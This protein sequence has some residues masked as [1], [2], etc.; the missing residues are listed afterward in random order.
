MTSRDAPLSVFMHTNRA[1]RN[2]TREF[3]LSRGWW[4]DTHDLRPLHRRYERREF[5]YHMKFALHQGFKYQWLFATTR[6]EAEP[7]LLADTD[8]VIQCTAQEMRERFA[9]AAASKHKRSFVG[10]Y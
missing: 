7:W 8:V 4:A 10:G 9:G 1:V 3:H 5:P 6:A 2:A